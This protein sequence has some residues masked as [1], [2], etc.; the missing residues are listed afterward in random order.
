MEAK[1]KPDSE[2]INAKES[3]ANHGKTEVTAEH[4]DVPNEETM[5]E[6]TGALEDQFGE[7]HL[8]IG[9]CQQLKK[10]I[11]GDGGSRQ[12]L[13]TSCRWFTRCAIPALRKGHGRRGP[14][15]TPGNGIGGRSRR[16]EL[17]LG[18]KETFYVVLGQTHRL[19]IV[20]R[21][22]RFSIGL[23]KVTDWTS[24]RS[25]PPPKRKKRLQIAYKL[26]L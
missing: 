3:E 12:K 25:Q 1:I 6:T 9:R 11:Q 18:S 7:W 21:V 13:A 14:G 20:K 15:K 24:W 19:E 5:A 23:W 2:E 17:C 10:W 22:V 16:Q 26:E 4:Q 8:A